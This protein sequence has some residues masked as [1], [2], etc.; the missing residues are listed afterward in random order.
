M[1]RLLRVT[2]ISSSETAAVASMLGTAR[3]RRSSTR[4]LLCSLRVSANS[5]AAPKNKG[6]AIW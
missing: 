3:I 4:I 6:P 5:L 2:T 1:P